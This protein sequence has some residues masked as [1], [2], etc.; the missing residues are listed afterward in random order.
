M[1]EETKSKSSI[2][3]LKDA[4]GEIKTEDIDKAEILNDFFASVFTVEGDSEL[5]DFEPKVNEKDNI[6]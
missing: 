2:G 4:N 6:H 3:D 1:K 5:P